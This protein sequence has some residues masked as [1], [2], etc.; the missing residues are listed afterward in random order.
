MSG[1][2]AGLWPTLYRAPFKAGKPGGKPPA[3]SWPGI[4][5]PDTRPLTEGKQRRTALLFQNA[6]VRLFLQASANID[7]SNG[8]KKQRRNARRCSQ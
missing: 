8:T 5:C 1:S 2:W 6:L 3:P 4:V 7:A